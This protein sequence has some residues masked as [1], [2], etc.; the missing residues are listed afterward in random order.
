M[1]VKKVYENEA[2]VP[3]E[4]LVLY[5]ERD[6][7]WHLTLEVEGAASQ[8]DVTRL[9]GALNK[10]RTDHGKTKEKLRAFD[11]LDPQQVRDRLEKLDDLEANPDATIEQRVTGE[12]ERRIK[13]RLAPVERE[14]ETAKR[15]RDEAI[16]ERDR[17]AGTL[18][19]RSIRDDVR[20]AAME[21]KVVGTALDDVLL[22]GDSMFEQNE[23]GETVTKDG[24][25]GVT[26]GLKPSAWL[27][28]QKDRRPHW[29]PASQGAGSQGN[30]GGPGGGDNPFTA[31][32][33]NVTEQGKLAAAD[34][35]KAERLAKA[36]G[37]TLGGPKPAPR[38]RAA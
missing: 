28:D 5:E 25:A 3:A 12:V 30:R 23:A 8:D 29:W 19:S 31:E 37:T 33:W 11:G 15:E 1:R 34:Q 14:R 10:E 16:A 27:S 18:R 2:D 36:A 38:S 7:K 35:A 20:S 22:Y 6:G 21:A 24:I 32:A 13:A 9:Q 17:A 26:P 4:H